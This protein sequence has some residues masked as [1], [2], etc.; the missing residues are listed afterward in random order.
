MGWF[1]SLWILYTNSQIVF[2]LLQFY[3]AFVIFIPNFGIQRRLGSILHKNF[4][5]ENSLEF[6]YS[7][8]RFN[9]LSS[10]AHGR[11]FDILAWVFNRIRYCIDLRH[12]MLKMHL[13]Q[14]YNRFIWT[15][16]FLGCGKHTKDWN[17][18]WIENHGIDQFIQLH[19]RKPCYA[20]MDL[21]GF[22]VNQPNVFVYKWMNWIWMSL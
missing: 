11:C 3:L 12:F 7:I 2:I 22:S 4:N 8:N 10:L 9:S 6:L 19:F 21:I 1:L 14:S 16:P 13:L 18:W 20:L 5:G 17:V 15:K